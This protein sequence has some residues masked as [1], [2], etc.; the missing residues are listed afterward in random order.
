M[1]SG[2]CRHL[3]AGVIGAPSDV[4]PEHLLLRSD[5]PRFVEN[6]LPVRA[7][8]GGP[9][10]GVV[11]VYRVPVALFETIAHGMRLIWAI[12]LG[13][14]LVPVPGAVLDR[15][16]RRP[17][18]RGTERAPARNRDAGG[19]R[20]NDRRDHARHPQSAGLDPHLGRALPGRSVARRAR[21]GRRHHRRGRSA[22]RMGAAAAHLF[23]AGARAPRSRRPRALAGGEPAG[24]RARDAAAR[25][26]ARRGHRRRGCPRCAPSAS[27]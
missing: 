7:T 18:D 10:I 22:E 24:L 4:K 11:E 8:A 9:V 21:G 5:E 19:D 16:P 20:R 1:P 23:G 3:K 2:V 12:A 14:G 26:R 27:A 13:G 6:Y 15:A 17:P 25:R